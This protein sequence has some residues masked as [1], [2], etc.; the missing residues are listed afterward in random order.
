VWNMALTAAT[1]V[2]FIVV[3]VVRARTATVRFAAALLGL[4]ATVLD[5]VTLGLVY[6]T[7]YGPLLQW[8]GNVG[9]GIA[10]MLFVASW[11]VARRRRATW[12]LGLVPTFAIAAAVTLLFQLS[13]SNDLLGGLLLTWY[14]G[15]LLWVGAFVLGCLCCWAFDVGPSARTS[16][17]VLAATAS[18]T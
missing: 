10:L 18:A 6:Y 5:L 14:V 7:D 8:C 2:Y 1:D 9:G 11:G 17:V 4:L 16:P 3:V 15:W 12:R 13:W